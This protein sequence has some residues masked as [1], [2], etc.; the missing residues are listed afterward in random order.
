MLVVDDEE[1]IRWALGELFMQEGWEVHC[2]ADGDEAV[3]MAA[4]R[5]YDYLI[6]DLKMP[7]LPGVELIRQARRQDPRLGVTVLTGYASL[8]SAIEAVRLHAWDY[9][10]KP[11]KAAELKQGVDDFLAARERRGPAGP[12]DDEAL[13]RFLA[14][15]GTELLC[16][17]PGFHRRDGAGAFGRLRRVAA[18]LG[19][20]PDRGEA[21]VQACVEAAALLDGAGDC[22]VRA[23]L[24]EG[25]LLIGLVGAP[26]GGDEAQARLGRLREEFA[27]D[28]RVRTDDGRCSIVLSEAIRDA[29]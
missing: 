10:T 19:L 16:L 21:V 27:V 23:A 9:V 7:G 2:A 4:E 14:G 11:C 28:A 18:D 29:R 26:N 25:R 8:E 20:G 5:A 3:R 17:P 22:S 24:F 12:F 1:T 13:A 15:E 6:T